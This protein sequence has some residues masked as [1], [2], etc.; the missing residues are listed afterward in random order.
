MRLLAAA[1][2]L[3][4]IGCMTS[5]LQR[6]VGH[7]RDELVSVRGEPQLRIPLAG[8]AEVLEYRSKWNASAAGVCEVAFAVDAAGV[9]RATK[10]NKCRWNGWIE[11]PPSAKESR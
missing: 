4:A 1:A 6:W 11:G 9:I 5:S 8:G 10:A 3:F 7:T 2:A